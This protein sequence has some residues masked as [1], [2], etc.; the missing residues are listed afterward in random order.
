MKSI[1]RYREIY[2]TETLPSIYD[3]VSTSAPEYKGKIIHYLKS[4]KPTAL[5]PKVITDLF[6]GDKLNIP[7]YC[8]NDGVYNWRS[9]MIYYFEKYNL[10]LDDSFVNY[11]LEKVA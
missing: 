6:S 1:C 11:V 5:S 4:F 8:S 9:D 7:F 10:K 2:G 3:N